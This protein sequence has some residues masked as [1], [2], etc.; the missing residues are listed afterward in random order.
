MNLRTLT[1]EALITK[2][3]SIAWEERKLDQESLQYLMEIRRRRLY[4]EMAYSSLFEFCVKELRYSDGV[5]SIKIRAVEAMSELPEIEEKLKEGKLSTTVIATV[6]TFLRAE[7]KLNSAHQRSKEERRELFLQMEGKSKRECERVLASVAPEVM[8]RD[9]ERAVSATETEIRFTADEAL[10]KKLERVRQLRSHKNPHFSYNELFHDMADLLLR[11]LDPE[12]KLELEA[13]AEKSK[14]AARAN[15]AIVTNPASPASTR[16]IPTQIRREVWKKDQGR[17]AFQDTKTG[18]R[19]GSK[20]LLQYDHIQPFALGG[21][22]RAQNLRLLC[23]AHNQ[24]QV[25]LLGQLI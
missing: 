9:K 22:S 14:A 23:F 10:M 3:K 1:R 19:C 16:Y 15:P 18:K 2:A 8:K 20:H 4:A 25:R 13:K 12:Q 11:K 5:A 21:P 17:C 7:K 24:L 6:Q